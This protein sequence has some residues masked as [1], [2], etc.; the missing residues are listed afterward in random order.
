ML[1]NCRMVRKLNV[2]GKA[3]YIE[4]GEN[5]YGKELLI[6]GVRHKRTAYIYAN[7]NDSK[8]F[9]VRLQEYYKK[10]VGNKWHRWTG[11][12]CV[13]SNFSYKEAR[14]IGIDFV[15]RNIVKE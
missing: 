2:G 9:G 1:I 8:K 14:Q 13:G 4:Y 12:N 15:T 11:G 7:C 3:F 6:Y 10:P 5:C